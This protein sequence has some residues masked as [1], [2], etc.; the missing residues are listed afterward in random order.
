VTGATDNKG[1]SY[2]VKKMMSTKF[3]IPCLLIEMSEQLL[4]HRLCLDLEWTRRDK[5]QEADALTNWDFRGFDPRKRVL[6]DP[7][8]LPWLVLPEVLRA[9]TEMFE[10]MQEEGKKRTPSQRTTWPR[11]KALARLKVTDPW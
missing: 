1:N 7:T 2:I 9:S 11:Q 3:P 4:R 6:V 5:N 10:K 8:N